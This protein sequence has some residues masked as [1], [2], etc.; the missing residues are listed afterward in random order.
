MP[1]VARYIDIV[2]SARVADVEPG[3]DGRP[4]WKAG[5]D[6]EL[7]RVGGRWD[8]V[9]KRWV[10]G[11]TTGRVLPL[12][13]HRGQEEAA[14]WLA[15]WL[16]RF[17]RNDWTGCDRV[18]SALM[19]GGRRSGKTHLTCAFLILFAALAAGGR[20]DEKRATRIWAVSPTLETGDEL[21][22]ALREMLPRHWYRRFQAKTGRSTTFKLAN[23]SIILLR[24][25]VKPERL[26]AGRVDIVLL[27]EAQEMSLAAYL[28][29]RAP[30][31]DR[32]GLV[33]LAANPPEHQRGRWVEEHYMRSMAGEADSKAFMFDPRRNPWIDYAA[34]AS[35][36]KEA[37]EKTFEREILGLFRPIG[38]VVFHAWDDRE[39]WKDPPADLIDITP[40]V[41]R[42]EL[43]RP[44]GYI[45]GMDFQRTP[46]MVAVVARVF[47]EPLTGEEVVWIVDEAVIEEADENDLIDALEAMPRWR[48]GDRAPDTRGHDDT[49]RGWTEPTDSRDAPVHCSCVID[50]SGFFQDGDHTQGRTSDRFLRARGWIEL[51]KP[52]GDSDR[53]PAI[54]ERMK[55]G[56]ALLKAAS[57]TRRLFVARH[58]IRTAEAMR[59]YE[60]KNG[61]PNRRSR[62]AHVVDGVTYIAYRLY[63]RPKVKKAPVGYI[64]IGRF[65]RGKLFGK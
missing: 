34:L 39:N 49:Y 7:V 22:Q 42:R 36:A 9:L 61:G 57:G 33:L 14:R 63:G 28:K 18:W 44:A 27:N 64:P 41:T 65:T 1:D 48:L 21:D 15:D 16:T 13:F 53:N 5:T 20:G 45:V 19:I 32:G 4:L 46:A 58:C 52:Q 29:V 62:Y 26:K 37:D 60:I 40:L 2:I 35:M 50:A 11:A 30:V 25:G 6:E 43:G 47:R 3:P 55:T 24:S 8:R 51:H 54:V 59:Q 10:P 23:D 17:A 56:N 31:A 12:R 38:E